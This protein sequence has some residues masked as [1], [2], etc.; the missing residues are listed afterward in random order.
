MYK[1]IFKFVVTT[2]TI[3]T[4]N[5]LTV[6]LTDYL[7]SFKTHYRPIT[8]TLIAMGVITV[9]FYPLFMWLEDWLNDLS[10]KIVRSGKSFG[11]KYLGLLVIYVVCLSVLLYFYAK[12][13]YHIDLIRILFKGHIGSQI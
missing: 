4:V 8:F 2:L 11:G 3:L 9:I 10:A 7:V 13:W 1:T 12:M 6:K 5:L